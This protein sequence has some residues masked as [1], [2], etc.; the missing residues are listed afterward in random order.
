MVASK[1]AN[2]RDKDLNITRMEKGSTKVASKMANLKDKELN[3][4]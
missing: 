4:I 3:I 2:L 1:R